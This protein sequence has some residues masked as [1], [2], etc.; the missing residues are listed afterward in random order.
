MADPIQL[1]RRLCAVVPPDAARAIE[2]RFQKSQREAYRRLAEAP[3]DMGI[4]AVMERWAQEIA[5]LSLAEQR[6]AGRLKLAVLEGLGYRNAS[7]L[8]R[9]ALLRAE[10]LSEQALLAARPKRVPHGG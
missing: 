4:A 5:P 8:V 7:Q 6:Q 10:L 9:A 1:A 3:P 2:E